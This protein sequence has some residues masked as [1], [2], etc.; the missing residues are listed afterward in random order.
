MGH[1]VL[2]L[3]KRTAIGVPVQCGEFVP[4]VEELK[5]MLPS[6]KGLDDI[7]DIPASLKARP[8]REIVLISPKEREFR[9]DFSGY[10]TWRDRFDAH[11]ASM[12]R[13]EGAELRTNAGVRRII[14]EDGRS[15]G[16]ELERDG[17]RVEAKVFVGADG[18][19]SIVAKCAGFTGQ[20]LASAVTCTVPGSFDGEVRM[21]FGSMAPGGYAWVIPKN[22]AA[23]VGVGAQT[24][25]A[26]GK[27]INTMLRDF[28][29][30]MQL[31][32]GA[33]APIGKR[34]PMNGPRRE[35]VRSNVMLVG[36]AAGHVMAT[37]GG[38]VPI[39]MICGR[40]AGK[41]ISDHLEGKCALEEYD[42]EWRRQVGREL[43]TARKVKRLA[44]RFAFRSDRAMELCMRLLGRRRLERA[45]KCRPLFL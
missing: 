17:E 15:K 32:K 8:T 7:F 12:A 25:N 5:E 43:E 37:N 3:E 6:A 23:N 30:Y 28:L 45:I 33:S 26:R 24:K 10:S 13:K 9:F 36:D 31:E 16:V 20:V 11:L 14:F 21:C 29:R 41:V 27:T 1:R 18:P 40:I 22:D 42:L 39:A 38:G 35:T 19:D 2:V 34:V 44:D 4:E